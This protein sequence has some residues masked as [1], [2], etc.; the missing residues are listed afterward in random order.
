MSKERKTSDIRDK[1]LRA[2]ISRIKLGRVA[3]NQSTKLTI[4]AVAREAGVSTALIYNSHPDIAEII[5]EAQGSSSRSQRD[6]KHQELKAERLKGRALR[7][8]I[9]TLRIQVAKLTSINEVLIAEN[10]KL[11]SQM[12]SPKVVN[13]ATHSNSA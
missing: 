9:T 11:K 8:E 10:L 1:E 5:R 7:D 2:A 3:H 4:A 13:M 6:E 12:S